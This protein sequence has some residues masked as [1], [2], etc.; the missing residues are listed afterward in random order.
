M[1]PPNLAE[2][3]K[4]FRTA[5]LS[6]DD[7][8]VAEL[9]NAPERVSV[10]RNTVQASLVDVLATAFPVTQRIVGETF[11]AHLATRFVMAAPP[12]VPHL[13]LYGD[14]FAD[15]IAREDV[16]QRLPYLPDVARLEWARGESYFAA[17][18]PILDLA[19]LAALSPDDMDHIVLRLHPATRLISSTFPIYRIWEVN[20]PTVTDV[21]A[22]DMSIAQHVLI[23][24]RGHHLVTREIATQDAVFLAAIAK[25]QTLS[26]ATAYM[27]GDFDLQLAL[28][29]HFLQGTFRNI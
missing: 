7:A 13:S 24:R 6:A 17:D 14:G 11:F 20:Q 1:T 22:V 23:S 8:L 16:A 3:Q 26:R 12:R 5:V 19:Q 2:I 27:P 10:Y 28:Q 21:P 25:G 15:F 9:V 18:A 4:K 29:D